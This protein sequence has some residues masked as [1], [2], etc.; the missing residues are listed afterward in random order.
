MYNTILQDTQSFDHHMVDMHS[1]RYIHPGFN[2]NSTAYKI[3]KKSDKPVLS[4]ARLD[5][6]KLRSTSL[7]L[8]LSGQSVFR[9]RSIM[10]KYK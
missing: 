2:A 8:S 6:I 3:T 1:K 4:K 9:V 7:S 10:V 5:K